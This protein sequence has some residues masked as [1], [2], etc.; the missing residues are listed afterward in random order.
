MFMYVYININLHIFI[1]M[2]IYL[3]LYLYMNIY[4]YVCVCAVD[5]IFTAHSCPTSGFTWSSQGSKTGRY[6]F[7][8]TLGSL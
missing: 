4:I 8:G 2:Y 1:Y 7:T 3:Y 5:S 6:L